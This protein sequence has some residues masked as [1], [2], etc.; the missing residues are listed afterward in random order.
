ME[1]RKLP[2]GIFIHPELSGSHNLI[3]YLFCTYVF[4]TSLNI[5]LVSQRILI[6][7]IK[8]NSFNIFLLSIQH[9]IFHKKCTKSH[10]TILKTHRKSMMDVLPFSSQEMKVLL[11]FCLSNPSKDFV[12]HQNLPSQLTQNSFVIVLGFFI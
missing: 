7:Y 12:F 10:S 9:Y 8:M 5:Q 2:K 3:K 4:K 1:Y 6:Y 11:C